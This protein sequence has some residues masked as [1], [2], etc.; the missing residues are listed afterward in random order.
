MD[1]EHT[2]S[3]PADLVARN[4]DKHQTHA[5]SATEFGKPLLRSALRRRRNLPVRRLRAE[6]DH[7]WQILPMMLRELTSAA[8]NVSQS[9]FS[10]ETPRHISV[11]INSQE[12]SCD[13]NP[14]VATSPMNIFVSFV[15]CAR[16]HPSF[17]LFHSS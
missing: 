15:R 14:R 1:D 11:E 7:A 4:Q 13:S 3:E 2:G 10:L 8:A 5:G 6:I 17:V 12:A 16:S 9:Q